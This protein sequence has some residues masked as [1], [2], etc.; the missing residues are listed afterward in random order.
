MNIYVEFIFITSYMFITYHIIALKYK[1]SRIFSGNSQ[2]SK[3]FFIVLH[4]FIVITNIL[5]Y[6]R[7]IL[8]DLNQISYYFS[9][10][11]ILIFIFGIFMISW[12]IYTLGIAVFIPENKLIIA[13]PYKF[14][15]HPMYFGGITGAS[16]LA[17]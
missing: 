10:L 11:G 6:F 2:K 17:L 5:L 14:V 15:R 8:N 3:L 16:G 9:V 4:F 1:K 7:L 13:G 12:G